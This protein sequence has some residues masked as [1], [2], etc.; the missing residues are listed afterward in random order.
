MGN[1]SDFLHDIFRV[2]I[3]AE[4]DSTALHK[5]IRPQ[6][7]P[8][9]EG[10]PSLFLLTEKTLAY[11][12]CAAFDQQFLSA[13]N[14]SIYDTADA[15]V[16]QEL[17]LSIEQLTVALGPQVGIVFNEVLN[18]GFFPLPKLVLFSRIR[19]QQATEQVLSALRNRISERGFTK[20]QSTQ[21]DEHIIYYWN[22]LPQ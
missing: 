21:T 2:T 1:H 9:P 19:D 10:S 17:S 12:W 5:L 8:L 6:G 15:V 4:Y 14:K 20:E 18:T 11:Y 13:L 7:R 22:V 3:K 16:R